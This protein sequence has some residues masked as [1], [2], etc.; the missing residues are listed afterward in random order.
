[1][2]K[3]NKEKII[4][5]FKKKKRLI[6][7]SAVLLVLLTLGITFGRYIYQQGYNYILESQGFYFNSTLMSMEES[8]HSINNW[9]GVNAYPLTISVNNRKNDLIY[10]K[11]DIKYDITVSC[12]S[13]IR[14]VLSK[15]SGTILSENHVD[16][17]VITIYPNGQFVRNQTAEVTTTATSSYP[18]VK[19]LSATYHISVQTS[20]FSY[21]IIDSPG[22]KYLTL[23]L[24]NSFT[25][26]R[27]REAF[28]SYQKGDNISLDDYAL[29]SDEDKKK[30]FS[31]IVTL[32]FDPNIILLDMTDRT[33]LNRIPDSENLQLINNHQ[34]VDKFAFNMEANTGNRIVF[35]KKDSSQNYAYPGTS[36]SI[37]TVDVISLEDY[38]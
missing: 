28:G 8:H 20:R 17:Y 18:Y 4:H 21:A 37:I 23:D 33:Y 22:S 25:Y 15:T 24:T 5:F 27:A 1:M 7:L 10:T 2:K 38:E 3:L 30:C 29:L 16:S 35:Y 12:S 9:D 14:C 34:F 31:A 19:K 36:P 32:S 11:S 13:N 26:Y 6:I